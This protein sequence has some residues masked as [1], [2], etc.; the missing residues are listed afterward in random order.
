MIHFFLSPEKKHLVSTRI[1]LI[2][3]FNKNKSILF[4]L[5]FSDE[6]F[7]KYNK[8]LIDGFKDKDWLGFNIEKLSVDLKKGMF[9]AVVWS[10]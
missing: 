7:E 8:E 10:V 3:P 9:I 5:T 6:T 2:I 1:L 4:E